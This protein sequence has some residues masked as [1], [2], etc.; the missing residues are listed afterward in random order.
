MTTNRLLQIPFWNLMGADINK[1]KNILKSASKF[2]RILLGLQC[3]EVDYK[4]EN[5]KHLTLALKLLRPQPC[6]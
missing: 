5:K 1:K 2:C 6:G 4:Q 3:C